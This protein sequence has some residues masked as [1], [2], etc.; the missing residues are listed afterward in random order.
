MT[1]VS[2]IGYGLVLSAGFEGGR[3][4]VL[5]AMAASRIKSVQPVNTGEYIEKKQWNAEYHGFQVK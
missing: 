4:R 5:V 2:N 3:E 1:P